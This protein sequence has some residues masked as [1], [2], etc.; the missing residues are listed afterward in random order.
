MAIRWGLDNL[1]YQIPER[2]SFISPGQRPGSRCASL[3]KIDPKPRWRGDRP[4]QPGASN[5]QPR[6]PFQ[7]KSQIKLCAPAPGRCPG[8]LKIALAGQQ[9]IVLLPAYTSQKALISKRDTRMAIR[10]GL[11]YL[12]Y[13]IPERDSFISPGQRP[14]SRWALLEKIDPKPRWRG[15]RPVQPGASNEQ[16]RLPFQGKSQIKLCAPSP[17]RCPGLLKIALAGQT[18]NQS[19]G[20]APRALPWALEDCPC[21]A[22]HESITGRRPQGVA[23]GS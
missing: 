4:V 12:N 13:Q 7:G 10:R 19:L 8:L 18:M 14:G 20:T 3:E 22:N 15:D 2:D 17:G 21:R 5:E 6:L 11:D 9:G 1:N 23:L 16:P